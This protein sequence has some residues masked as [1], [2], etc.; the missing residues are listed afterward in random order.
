MPGALSPTALGRGLAIRFVSGAARVHVSLPQHHGPPGRK[1]EG[2]VVHLALPLQP[3]RHVDR[4]VKV[5]TNGDGAMVRNQHRVFVAQMFHAIVAELWSSI[6]VVVGALHAV[7]RREFP[8]RVVVARQRLAS[9][10][11]RASVHGVGV[12]DG[13]HVGPRLVHPRVEVDLGRRL[14]ALPRRRHPIHRA[15]HHVVWRELLVGHPRR[16]D[17]DEVGAG[18]HPR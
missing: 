10:R 16:L 17:D 5:R 14:E 4:T 1:R 12:H 18:R 6:C 8:H 15:Q 2:L 9:A 13:A 7:A 3:P 11:E